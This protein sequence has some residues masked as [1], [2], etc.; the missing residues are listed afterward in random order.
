MAMVKDLRRKK[1]KWSNLCD[2]VL[3]SH[4]NEYIAMAFFMT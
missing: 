2:S 1:F 3:S 4:W